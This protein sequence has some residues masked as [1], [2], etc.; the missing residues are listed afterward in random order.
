ML[1]VFIIILINDIIDV[2]V[3]GEYNE[4][5]FIYSNC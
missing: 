1:I 3:G 2:E 5:S 4:K